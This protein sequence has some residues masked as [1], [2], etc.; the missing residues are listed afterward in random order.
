MDEAYYNHWDYPYGWSFKGDVIG[1]PHI[2]SLDVVPIS[3]V[4]IGS[5][6]N[7]NPILSSQFLLSRKINKQDD[8]NFLINLS[9]KFNNNL[10]A[11][12]LFFSDSG[13]VGIGLK[14]SWKL[15]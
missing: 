13:N 10:S 8:L 15:K 1:N 9:R 12:I 7:I 14:T 11:G 5:I 2:N 3:A 4:H 6:V